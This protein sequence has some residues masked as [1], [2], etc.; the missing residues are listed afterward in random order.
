MPTGGS[1]VSAIS[2]LGGAGRPDIGRRQLLDAVQ[3]AALAA[4]TGDSGRALL[5]AGPLQNVGHPGVLPGDVSEARGP[6]LACLPSGPRELHRGP[7]A[8]YPALGQRVVQRPRVH[9]RAIARAR[10]WAR[11]PTRRPECAGRE[12]ACRFTIASAC[13]R[14]STEVGAAGAAAATT[15]APLVRRPRPAAC[16]LPA[17]HCRVAPA[18]LSPQVMTLVVAAIAARPRSRW[19]RLPPKPAHRQAGGGRHPPAR[20]EE[21]DLR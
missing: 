16:W 7:G 21:Q 6:H 20:A 8:G 17:C 4:C 5:T 2:L 15:A 11:R 14:L 12:V 10:R 19:P 13:Q 3:R 9:V 18:L 1:E